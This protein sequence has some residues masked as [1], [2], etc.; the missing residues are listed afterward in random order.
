MFLINLLGIGI[1]VIGGM[2]VVGLMIEPVCDLKDYWS[3][4]EINK[5]ETF[6]KLCAAIIVAIGV[7]ISLVLFSVQCRKQ[8][9]YQFSNVECTIDSGEVVFD[10]RINSIVSEKDREDIYNITL[11]RV[12]YDDEFFSSNFGKVF[13]LSDKIKAF[14]KTSSSMD[15][16]LTASEYNELIG[17][18]NNRFRTKVS[19]ICLLT[20]RYFMEQHCSAV[21]LVDGFSDLSVSDD[22]IAQIKLQFLE[23]VNERNCKDCFTDSDFADVAISCGWK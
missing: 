2:I 18:G 6:I 21:I 22:L 15:V 4:K 14:Y 17:K 12:N 9:E 20:E 5:K 16:V 23:Q 19:Y 8:I 1:V 3:G 13:C 10:V 11:S 7:I